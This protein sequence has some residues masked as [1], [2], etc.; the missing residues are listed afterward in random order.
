MKASGSGMKL[1]A[2]GLSVRRGVR[3]LFDRLDLDLV[4]GEVLELAGANGSGKSTLMRMLSG[5]IR[6]DSGEIRWLGLP[7]EIE[8]RTF[9]HYHGHHDGLRDALTPRENLAFAASLLGGSWDRIEPALAELDA[10]HLADLPVQVLSAGQRRRVALA[11]LL[12]APR[13]FWLLDEPL[14]ALD[15]AGQRIV[16]D[17]VETHARSGGMAIVAT[18]QPLGVTARRLA[19]GE[20]NGSPA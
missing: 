13:P 20:A 4:A 7:S 17:L 3:L 5:L 12:V 11:R 9:T 2:R 1:E 10:V 16:A 19:L 6:P 18:H 14:A 8:V 15:A